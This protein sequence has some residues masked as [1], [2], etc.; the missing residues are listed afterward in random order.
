MCLALWAEWKEKKN[1]FFAN[2]EYIYKFGVSLGSSGNWEVLLQPYV[3]CEM[4]E[5]TFC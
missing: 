1:L 2:D 3:H 5:C 4:V